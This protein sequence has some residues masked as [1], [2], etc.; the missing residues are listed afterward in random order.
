MS[1]S[2]LPGFVL[3]DGQDDCG[4]ISGLYAAAKAAADPNEIR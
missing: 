4:Y 1:A 3:D 2:C